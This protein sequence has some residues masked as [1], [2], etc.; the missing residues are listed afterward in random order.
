MNLV[1]IK[2]LDVFK[3]LKNSK[4]RDK[5]IGEICLN[6]SNNITRH[7][8]CINIIIESDFKN[9]VVMN[10]IKADRIAESIEHDLILLEL[11]E[12]EY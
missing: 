3:H 9:D 5:I 10:N 11:F 1:R 6:I 2:A 12:V 7:Q 8:E 4:Q